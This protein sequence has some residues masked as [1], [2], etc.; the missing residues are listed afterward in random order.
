M[1]YSSVDLK[2][3]KEL[4]LKYPPVGLKFSFFKPEGIERLDKKMPLCA[5]IGE[6]WQRGIFF[7][8]KDN[9]DCFG[10][11]ALGMVDTPRFAEAGLIGFKLGIFKEPRSNSRIYTYL[12]KVAKGTVNYV[13]FATLDHINFNPDL[14]I[15]LADVPKAEIIFRAIDN[16]CGSPRESKTTGV[17]GCAWIFAYPYLSGKVNW[18]VTGLHFGSKV[19]KGFPE[20]GLILISVPFDWIPILVAELSN[21]QWELPA[22]KQTAEEFIGWERIMLAELAHKSENP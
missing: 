15:I 8:D 19:K 13:S 20:E 17:F 16:Y 18:T 3:L 5:M 2:V 12:P 10:A 21:I 6:A 7:I 9:E 1:E 11:V 14:L 22:Y 4:G